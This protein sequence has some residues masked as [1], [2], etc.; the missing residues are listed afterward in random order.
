MF[1][2][3][4]EE[5]TA[6]II[7]YPKLMKAIDSSLVVLFES[8]NVGVVIQGNNIHKLGDHSDDWCDSRFA[9]YNKPITLQN[10]V[11]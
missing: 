6:K 2:V 9:D 8:Q 11:E 1:K 10:V 4:T 5:K 7:G 3:T